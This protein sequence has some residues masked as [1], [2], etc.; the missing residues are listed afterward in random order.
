MNSSLFPSFFQGGFECSTHRRFDGKRLDL[1]EATRHDRFALKDYRRLQSVGLDTARDGIRWHLIEKSP[2]CYDWSSALPQIRAAAQSGQT[3]IWD[4]LHYGWP[5]FLDVWSPEWVEHFARFARAFAQ[6]LR[7]ESDGPYFFCPVNEPSF[8]SFAAADFGFFA[9]HERGRGWEFKQ[10]LVRATL[11]ASD[12]I[13]DVLPTARLIQTDPLVHVEAHPDRPHERDLA[14]QIT[15]AQFQALDMISGRLCPELGGAEHYLDVLGVNFYVHNQWFHPGG[16]DSMIPPSHPKHRPLRHLL[17][18]IH[19]RYERPILIAETGIEEDARPQW[20]A[21]VAAEA[22][23]ALLAG[24]PVE[25]VCLYPICNHPGWDND[26]HCHN[27]LFDYPDEYGEREV[28]EPMARELRHQIELTHRF[29]AASPYER[30]EIV[31]RDAEVDLNQ[32]DHA[33]REMAAAA[34]V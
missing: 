25:G 26:R 24:V 6:L 31:A 10:Q 30:E 21:R 23:A 14:G 18:W 32:L 20:L 19:H 28:Y 17:E 27:G 34:A 15:H 9:P 11:A 4:V 1:I 5:D 16:P 2:G 8:F 12:E 7:E 13:W 3:V 29:F 22:R 33:A